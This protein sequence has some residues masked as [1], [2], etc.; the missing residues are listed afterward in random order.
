MAISVTASLSV[1]ACGSFEWIG[2]LDIGSITLLTVNGWFCCVMVEISEHRL[3]TLSVQLNVG[4]IG[5]EGVR[6][7]RNRKSQ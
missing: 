3:P 2:A 5:K 6:N 4:M 7:E 1:R